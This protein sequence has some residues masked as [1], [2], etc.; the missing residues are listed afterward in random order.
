MSRRP[1]TAERFNTILKRAARKAGVTKRVYP[2]CSTTPERRISQSS[3]R[4][5]AARL[6]RV[7]NAERYPGSIRASLGTRRRCYSVEALR[8]RGERRARGGGAL[9]QAMSSMLDRQ[10]TEFALLHALLDVS[11]P[12]GCGADGRAPRAGRARRG[13]IHRGNGASG[14][15][16]RGACCKT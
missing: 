12:K 10:P 14:P 6:F 13:T 16:G 4:S 2:T 3:H 11:R 1:I 9:T 15:K 7:D 8:G 5:P